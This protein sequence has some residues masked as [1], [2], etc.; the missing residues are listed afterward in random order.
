MP[1][2]VARWVG[3]L[4]GLLISGGVL[5]FACNAQKKTRPPVH[6]AGYSTVS[7]S[8]G[9]VNS[10]SAE[11]R[12]RVQQGD[13]DV[14]VTALSHQ[15]E[16]VE[17]FY[18]YSGKSSPP[19]RTN[20]NG[21]TSTGI[22]KNDVSALFLYEG[23][24][25][26]S[27]AIIHGRADAPDSNGGGEAIFDFDGLPLPPAQWVVQDDD[28]GSPDFDSERDDTPEWTWGGKK[29]DGGAWRGGLDAPFEI[30]IEPKALTGIRKWQVLSGDAS[31]PTRHDLP[32]LDETV[33]ISY[34][35]NA[36]DEI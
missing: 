6:D 19:G 3:T 25:G 9:A 29:T 4:L 7:A 36:G 28:V 27:L 30:S 32:A 15:G 16:T 35:C 5:F 1:P 33:T 17:A 2:F 11:R 24:K 34:P 10:D 31:D 20:S 14:C 18:G 22:E 21:Y 23:P 12:F 26:T 13:E 8:T